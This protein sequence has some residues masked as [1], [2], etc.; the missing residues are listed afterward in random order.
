MLKLVFS[1]GGVEQLAPRGV[2]KSLFYPIISILMAVHALSASFCMQTFPHNLT[3]AARAGAD[4]MTCCNCI[5]S[6]PRSGQARRG[7]AL[8]ASQCNHFFGLRW[9]PVSMNDSKKGTAS[10][11][12]R[13]F[14]HLLITPELMTF[15]TLRLSYMHH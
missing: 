14:V 8:R 3:I 2:R 7:K 1:A 11:V 4:P 5:N 10:H 9:F 15:N 12:D 6:D 13:K